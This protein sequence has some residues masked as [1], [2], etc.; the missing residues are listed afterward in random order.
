M[1]INRKDTPKTLTFGT[2]SVGTTFTLES[3]TAIFMKVDM[4]AVTHYCDRCDN[5][6]ELDNDY[7]VNFATGEM[8]EFDY[9]L[10]VALV[11]CE[12]NEI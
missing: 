9:R 2:I 10:P 12:L 11:D 3:R 4:S 7:A 5:D 6:M 1:K 8:E